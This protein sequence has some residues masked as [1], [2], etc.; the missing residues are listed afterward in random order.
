MRYRPLLMQTTA[1]RL[2]VVMV[3]TLISVLTVPQ[4]LA[5]DPGQSIAISATPVELFENDPDTHRIGRLI[6]RAGFHLTSDFESFGGFSGLVVEDGRLTAI[7][8]QGHWLSATLQVSADGTLEGLADGIMG[9]LCDDDG[10]PVAGWER[11]DAEEIQRLPEGGFVVSFERHHRIMLYPDVEDGLQPLA[12]Q[13][14]SFAFPPSIVTT[15]GNKGMEAVAVLRDGRLLTF[16][17]ELRT[18]ED[19]M[20]GWIGHPAKDAWQHLTL[21]ADDNYLPTGAATLPSGNVVLLERYFVK[22]WGNRIRLRLLAA[23]N[24]HA[25]ARLTPIELGRIEPPATVDNM[26]AIAIHPGPAGEVLIYL[27]SDNNFSDRQR[28]LLLQL[29][30]TNENSSPDP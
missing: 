15:N 29:E 26:E 1:L 28:T 25:D 10:E 11:R 4:G 19:D 27:L 17:E 24:L 9:S 21:A 23:R 6:Y 5:A 14:R 13:P 20:I 22:G 18:I 16:A 3:W 30:L 8:D 7:S 12:G 2:L